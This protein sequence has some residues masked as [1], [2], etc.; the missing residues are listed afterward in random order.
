M[1][2]YI[3]LYFEEI[4]YAGLDLNAAKQYGKTIYIYRR[5]KMYSV[6]QC[7][8]PSVCCKLHGLP[9]GSASGGW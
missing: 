3:V 9:P 7:T 5:G 4:L 8:C 2:V 1:D 6:L